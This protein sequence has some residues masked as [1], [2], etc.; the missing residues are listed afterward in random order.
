MGLFNEKGHTHQLTD[1]T[2]GMHHAAS[3]T[4]AMLAQQYMMMLDQYFDLREDGMYDAK[5]VNLNLPDNKE[6]TVPLISLI[7]PRGLALEN[8]KV[9]LSVK[10][11]DMDVKAA[12]HDIDGSQATRS[13]FK[14]EL[15][16]KTSANGKR[17]SSIIDIEMEF[18]ALDPP[19]GLMRTID[20]FASFVA[21]KKAPAAQIQNGR[22]KNGLS[23]LWMALNE[24]KAD[25]RILD[26][27]GRNGYGIDTLKKGLELCRKV[28]K[29]T[30]KS[31]RIQF[32]IEAE[33][34][35][36]DKVCTPTFKIA[37]AIFAKNLSAIEKLS[38]NRPGPG[39][40]P[41]WFARA[42][43]FYA[44]LLNSEDF[45]ARMSK[46]GRDSQQ[47]HSEYDRIKAVGTLI[48]TRSRLGMAPELSEFTA[49]KDEFRRIAR[50]AL[51]DEPFLLSKLFPDTKILNTPDDPEDCPV[52]Q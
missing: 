48:R 28:R 31:K 18:K 47:L 4:S 11:D 33:Q 14:V 36:A 39:T 44:A 16:P 8:M 19:E 37:R 45:L 3:T 52:T 23:S 24:A 40:A 7:H 12:T 29:I 43:R 17:D 38:L 6:I 10:I 50:I 41:Q 26:R 5:T 27:L 30:Q 20:Q 21:P 22:D 49:W 1:I 9:A 51:E 32:E 35:S 34:K 25:P 46:Y 42:D 15:S 13:A 2:R